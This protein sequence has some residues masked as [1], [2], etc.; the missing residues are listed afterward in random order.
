MARTCRSL[1]VLL[2]LVVAFAGVVGASVSASGD[3]GHSAT[4]GLPALPCPAVIQLPEGGQATNSCVANPDPD[5]YST[6]GAFL[7]F[8]QVGLAGSVRGK[9]WTKVP[10]SM[11]AASVIFAYTQHGAQAPGQK[12]DVEYWYD[13]R[14]FFVSPAGSK[15]PYGESALIPVRTVA[16]GSIPV[17]ITL[18]VVQETD[19]QGLPEPLKFRPHD[20][21]IAG[22][23]GD[24]TTVV[25]PS[26]L[27]A[28]VGVR[29]RSLVVDGVDVG[30][31]PRCRTAVLGGLS[32]STR[33]LQVNQPLG[34]EAPGLE[35]TG[36]SRNGK[37]EE[38][39]FDPTIYQYGIQGGTLTG[40]LD[41]PRFSGC[42]TSTGDDVSRLLTSAISASDNPVSVRI[43]ATNCQ[44]Y[45]FWG[46]DGDYSKY[47]GR[48]IPAGV[49]RPQDPKSGCQDSTHPNPKIVTVPKQFEIPDYAPGDAPD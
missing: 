7:N 35:G 47:G 5:D 21:R 27:K 36:D 30:L 33:E 23:A 3:E 40:R 2:A 29:V 6:N 32:L 13:V 24:I 9:Q 44:I 42:S 8:P 39:V 15:N 10:L 18:Q 11:V 38:E 16:F 34:Y 4:P 17:E 26:T 22:A 45:D 37:L 25:E 28:E 20:Y 43:G 46:Q 1:L 48:P 14:S 31:G 41:I 19:A 12:T 49:N